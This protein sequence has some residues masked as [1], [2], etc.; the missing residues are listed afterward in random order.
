MVDRC[1]AVPERCAEDAD[2]LAFSAA[3]A[4]LATDTSDV[5]LLSKHGPPATRKEVWSYYSFYA[6]DNGIGAYQ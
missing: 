4:P 2:R 1:E 5:N 6:A 3:A